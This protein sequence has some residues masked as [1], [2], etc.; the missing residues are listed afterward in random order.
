MRSSPMLDQS[1]HASRP[2]LHALVD[3]WWLLLLRGAAAVAFGVLALIWPG[4]TLG[5]LVLLYGLFALSD[6]AIAIIGAIRGTDHES[7]WWL[8]TVGVLGIAAGVVT[9]VR[10]GITSLF[11]LVCIALWA[12]ATGI[13]Q[14]V[15]AIS[16]R[17]EIEDEWLLIA[18]GA[19]SVIF[20][21]FL[22]AWP[23][24][25]ALALVLVIAAY[26]IAYGITLIVL[27]LRLRT[28]ASHYGSPQ[29]PEPS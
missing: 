1:D 26:A 7:R 21:G 28:H 13:A 3:R 9:L 19:L 27:A 14:I 29:H 24:T 18:S 2:M 6:G 17:H 20:G 22:L 12:I 16:M 23:G 4:V 11:L 8:A 5:T 25:G 15:G 10:P